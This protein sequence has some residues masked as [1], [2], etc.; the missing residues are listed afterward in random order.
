MN[1]IPPFNLLKKVFALPFHFFSRDISSLQYQK[2]Q[3]KHKKSIYLCTYEV[4]CFEV[5][6]HEIV[7]ASRDFGIEYSSNKML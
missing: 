3:P 2:V 4:H 6:K 7:S 5:F 1:K